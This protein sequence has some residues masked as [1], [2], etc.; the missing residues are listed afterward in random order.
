MI[1]ANFSSKYMERT[2]FWFLAD[3][4]VL[5]STVVIVWALRVGFESYFENHV[6][7]I[8]TQTLAAKRKTQEIKR[9]YVDFKSLADRKEHLQNRL[10]GLRRIKRPIDYRMRPV[11]IIRALEKARPSGIWFE[12]ISLNLTDSSQL[13][14]Q[15]PKK[16]GISEGDIPN[17]R[18]A[19]KFESLNAARQ[20]VVRGYGINN[21]EISRFLTK[22][23]KGHRAS[24]DIY[25]GELFV[26]SIDQANMYVDQ[27][28]GLPVPI[29]DDQVIGEDLIAVQASSFAIRVQY[30]FGGKAL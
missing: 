25:F 18:N 11:D 21:T 23:R 3:I 29:T 8:Q 17:S 5:I 27:S 6:L 20:V 10:N 16:K 24:K 28:E 13:F 14:E 12:S 1:G 22:I 30:D 15:T 7:N 2:E 9:A 19:K 26:D 4:A